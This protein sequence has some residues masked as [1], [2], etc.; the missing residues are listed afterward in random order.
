MSS[1][2][3]LYIS[4]NYGLQHQD[5]H[6]SDAPYKVEDLMP[7]LLIAANSVENNLFRIADIGAGVGGVL[8]ECTQR[9]TKAIKHLECEAVGF[10]ISPFAVDIGRK[11]FPN[12]DLR[13]KTFESSDGPFDVLMFVDVLE[14]LENP[15]ELLRI[16]NKSSEYMIIRQP[17]LENFSTFRHNNYHNQREEWGHIAYFNY[18][19]FMDMAYA[20]GWKPIKVNL[21]ANWELSGKEKKRASLFNRLIVKS[22]R[23]LASYLISGFYLNGIF[24]K[25]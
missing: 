23:V 12:I 7:S 16:A 9:I 1:S 24:K 6:L 17:L 19:S 20:T 21:L 15:W 5:W 22:N 8:A 3:D 10:E 2:T 4:G 18:Y 13:Q 11:L 25:A 14:H